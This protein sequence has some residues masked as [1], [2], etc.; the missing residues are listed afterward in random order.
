[1]VGRSYNEA[2]LDFDAISGDL[3][4]LVPPRVS[5]EEVLAR[6]RDQMVAQRRKGVSVAQMREVLNR[7]GI[8]IS[9][10]ALRIYLDKGELPVTRKAA[11][12]GGD[13]RVAGAD[14]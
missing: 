8:D 1:M 13:V 6:V 5:L 4:K 2:D 3:G 9:E 14:C 12:K 11:P 7:R 10:R